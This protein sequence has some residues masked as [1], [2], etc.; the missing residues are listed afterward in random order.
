MKTMKHMNTFECLECKTGDLEQKAFLEHLRTVHGYE[1]AQS[2]RS[3]VQALDGSGWFSNTFEWD[4]P[5]KDGKRIK[6]IQVSAGERSQ[7]DPM[8]CEGD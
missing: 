7:D 8:R 5:V 1:R 4:I 2:T 3:L 6:A